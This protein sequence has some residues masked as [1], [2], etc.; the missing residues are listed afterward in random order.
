MS[1]SAAPEITSL[2][3]GELEKLLIELRGPLA[4]ATYQVVEGLL[5]TLQ[6][7]L[8]TLEQKT[9]SL[10]R[11][12]RMIFGAKTEKASKVL[13]ATVAA[14]LSG[15]AKPKAK[16]HGRKAAKDYPAARRVEVSHPQH[17]VGDLCPK[18]LKAKLYRFATP[19][20]LV[21][22]VARPIFNATVFELERLRCALCGA[23]FTAPAPAEAGLGKYD[24]SVGVMLA[25]M[26]YGAGLPMY[27]TGKWQNHF[28]VP[29]P[30][31][32]QW[33]LI[34]AASQTPQ[35]IYE[36]LI[37][38]AAQGQLLF[39]DDTHM[40]VQSVRQEIA[41]AGS[42]QERTGIFTTG[43]ISKA[44]SRQIALFFTGQ[45]HAGENLN[46]VLQ[47]RA[48]GLDQPIQMCDALSRNEPKEFGTLLC[49]CLLHGRRQF[50][51]VVEKFPEECRR[52]I[53]SLRE[54]YRFDAI[55]KEQ[56]LSDL[57]RLAFHQKHSQ[58]VMDDLQKWMH[59]QIEQKRVEP[60]SGLGEAIRYMLK[61]WETLT[62]FL[63][64][65]GAPLDNNTAE[66]ALK[67][68]ILHRKNSLSFKTLHGARIGDVHMS[69]IHTSE[70]N[71]VNPFDYLM[72]LQQHA[73][74]VAKAPES[75]LPWN[76]QEAIAAAGSG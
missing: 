35:V 76:Y 32:T 1:K 61:R 16:G 58:S 73:A 21:R 34:E 33:E 48:A 66:R 75:W 8:A 39:N 42:E 22:I 28:G 70:L 52:V 49:H 69:L 41:A 63:S 5:R 74:A 67:M 65:P 11:L 2:S 13:P 25:L 44:G 9:A 27:R 51:D 37:S 46:Q 14:I 56:K 62:R 30:A 15:P 20:R 55:A 36:T 26:R 29:L 6:W 71:R 23:L 50:V 10:A 38:V 59:E 24:P 4:P 40:R 3:A 72:A 19:A 64:V 7:V 54:V 53:E 45:K 43:I 60:N 18:C 31:S 47:R 17:R 12:R 57:D 68:A